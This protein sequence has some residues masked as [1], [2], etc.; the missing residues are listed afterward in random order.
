MEILPGDEPGMHRTDSQDFAVILS[1]NLELLHDDGSKVSLSP[2]DV[3][4]QNGTRHVWRVVGDQ[5]ATKAA[6]IFGP[7]HRQSSTLTCT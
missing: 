6:F 4:V 3:V 1:G 7:Y 5:P 2:G